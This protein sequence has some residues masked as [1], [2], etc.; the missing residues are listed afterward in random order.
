MVKFP[1]IVVVYVA[2]SLVNKDEY[3]MK[4]SM[5]VILRYISIYL[6]I[7][8]FGTH[9]NYTSDVPDGALLAISGL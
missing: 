7:Y 3:I 5:I 8:D 6:S 9:T 4:L 1:V 2:T